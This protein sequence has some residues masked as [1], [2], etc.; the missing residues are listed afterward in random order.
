M[1]IKPS[2]LFFVTKL[3][4]VILSESKKVMNNMV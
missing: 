1:R 4:N 3:C 2:Q